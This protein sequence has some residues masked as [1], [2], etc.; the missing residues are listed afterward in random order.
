MIDYRDTSTPG[1]ARAA[2]IAGL[3]EGMR[4]TKPAVAIDDDGY[5]AQPEENLISGLS[6]NDFAED[7]KGAAG[8][9][10]MGKFRA[11]H[12]S[13]AL[14]INCFAPLRASAQRFDI[15]E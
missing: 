15:G 4:H 10:L 9:E 3:V 2:C 7:L 5:V 8:Q 1:N 13:A 14:A 12:S 11:V 6:L